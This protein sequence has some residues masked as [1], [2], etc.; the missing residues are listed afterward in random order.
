[1]DSWHLKQALSSFFSEGC[2][3]R[4]QYGYI[5][6][7]CTM[8]LGNHGHTLMVH[9]GP[10]FTVHVGC[11]I[12]ILATLDSRMRKP[13][14]EFCFG[15]TSRVTINFRHFQGLDETVDVAAAFLIDLFGVY[16]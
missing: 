12:H 7:H 2:E 16:I 11:H 4:I 1:M 8:N 14:Q 9:V 3:E 15:R 13:N 10:G 5:R 6:Y